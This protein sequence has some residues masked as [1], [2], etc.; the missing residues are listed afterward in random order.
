MSMTGLAA[1]WRS[2]CSPDTQSTTGLI[3]QIG[4]S[5]SWLSSLRIDGNVRLINP[6]DAKIVKEFVPVTVGP[7]TAAN[8]R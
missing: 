8:A 6:K 7:T 5:R 4:T 1:V 2:A 3:L